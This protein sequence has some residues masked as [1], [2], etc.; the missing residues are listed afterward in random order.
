MRATNNLTKPTSEPRSRFHSERFDIY[1]A[2]FRKW[3][4]TGAEKREELKPEKRHANQGSILA[5]KRSNFSLLVAEY[6]VTSKGRGGPL[7]APLKMRHV[8]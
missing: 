2:Y 4:P 5:F 7:F 8:A 1:I 6:E 3:V